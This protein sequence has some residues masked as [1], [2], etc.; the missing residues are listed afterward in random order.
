MDM[1]MI[2]LGSETDCKT[3]DVVTIYGGEMPIRDVAKRIETIPYEVTC[4]VSQRVPRIH[5]YE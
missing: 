1:I 3:G 4:N 5:N 2:D